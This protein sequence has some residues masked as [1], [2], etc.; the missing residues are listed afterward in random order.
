MA[1]IA[2]TEEAGGYLCSSLLALFCDLASSDTGGVPKGVLLVFCI[3]ESSLIVR[4]MLSIVVY[5]LF[6]LALATSLV[7]ISS[8]CWLFGWLRGYNLQSLTKIRWLISGF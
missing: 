4:F 6:V 7:A 1:Y 2:T 8:R 5:A 3:C